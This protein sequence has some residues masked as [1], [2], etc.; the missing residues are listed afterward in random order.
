[1]SNH[2]FNSSVVAII[3]QDGCRKLEA[4]LDKVSHHLHADVSHFS[5]EPNLSSQQ[6]KDDQSIQTTLPVTLLPACQTLH[7]VNTQL[8]FTTAQVEEAET[9]QKLLEEL[10]EHAEIL[11]RSALCE[12]VEQTN[13]D[14]TDHVETLKKRY[15]VVHTFIHN[16]YAQLMAQNHCHQL[17]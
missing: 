10:K 6:K 4:W 2:D 7:E 11:H 15:W 17:L 9:K 8:N 16:L 14:W 13:Q 5:N 1:Y 12:T 3:F